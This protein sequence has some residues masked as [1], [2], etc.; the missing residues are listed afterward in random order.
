[1]VY[2]ILGYVAHSVIAT[3]GFVLHFNSANFK[4]ATHIYFLYIFNLKCTCAL[5]VII[6]LSCGP[7]DANWTN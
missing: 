1:M 4:L 6:D 2:N 5:I 3:C 7:R